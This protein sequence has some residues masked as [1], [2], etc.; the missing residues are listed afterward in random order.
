MEAVSILYGIKKQKSIPNSFYRIL[1]ESQPLARINDL[2][3]LFFNSSGDDQ[4][5]QRHIFLRFI[6]SSTVTTY[7][8]PLILRMAS[9]MMSQEGSNKNR[10]I[11]Q[12]IPIEIDQ[13]KEESDARTSKHKQKL[14]LEIVI[15]IFIKSPMN[16]KSYT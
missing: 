11:P 2:L 5:K 7:L 9:S 10:S 12:N 1:K 8:N 15:L 16:L 4:V 6:S 14:F 13:L 3:E